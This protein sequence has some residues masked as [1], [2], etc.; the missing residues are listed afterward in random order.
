MNGFA[1]KSGRFFGDVRGWN[2]PTSQPACAN[3]PSN[4]T[5]D[6]GRFAFAGRSATASG[7]R[8]LTARRPVFP[9]TGPTEV[10]GLF[11]ADPWPCLAR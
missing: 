7:N 6:L 9:I 8:D 11:P 3:R 10:S 4:S 5:P 2:D 1:L